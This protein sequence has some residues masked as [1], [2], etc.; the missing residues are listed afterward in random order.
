[1]AEGQQLTALQVCS[2]SELDSAGGV[3]GR[4]VCSPP[5][6]ICLDRGSAAHWLASEGRVC[7]LCW[8]PRLLA[9]VGRA[10]GNRCAALCKPGLGLVTFPGVSA[11]RQSPASPS[12]A[13]RS[14][15]AFF[16]PSG[17]PVPEPRSA[18]ES[19]RLPLPVPRFLYLPY[20]ARTSPRPLLLR[21]TRTGQCGRR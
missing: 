10:E 20:G 17:D 6:P 5:N 12:P 15:S 8:S 7:A 16:P 3:A 4:G 19:E 11:A 14:P 9:R 18:T 21:G 1:M 13:I 2:V